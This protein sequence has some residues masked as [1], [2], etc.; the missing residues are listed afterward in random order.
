MTVERTPRGLLWLLLV[1]GVASLVHFVHN[2]EYLAYYPNLP[3]WLSRGQI[4]AVW[5]GITAV[6]VVGYVLHRAGYRLVGLGVV[7]AYAALGFDGLL[8]YGRA[9]FGEH[10]PAMNF[11]ILVEVA[12]AAVLLTYVLILMT[13][14][15]VERRSLP[16]HE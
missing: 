7:A 16:G 2:A 14:H 12:A 9:P 11:S 10:S 8:H 5:L 4:Y 6:G 15:V 1:Y 3:S 13:R